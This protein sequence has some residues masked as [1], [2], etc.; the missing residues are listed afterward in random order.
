MTVEIGS[1]IINTKVLLSNS[2]CHI[3]ILFNIRLNSKYY[4]HLHNS[5]KLICIK[6][7]RD[8]KIYLGFKINCWILKLKFNCMPFRWQTNIH[9]FI[10]T[11]RVLKTWQIWLYFLWINL[12]SSSKQITV[13]F[14]KS[15]NHSQITY[16]KLCTVLR[17]VWLLSFFSNS[18][19]QIVDEVISGR[20]FILNYSC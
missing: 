17:Q 14:V 16:C 10:N 8:F 18:V 5:Y 19:N 12:K 9:W 2:S 20:L 1:E 4:S 13:F 15:T 7:I 6:W 11:K 3:F